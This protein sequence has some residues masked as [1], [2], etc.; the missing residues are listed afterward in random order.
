VQPPSKL[1]LDSNHLR[2]GP[3]FGVLLLAHKDEQVNH[4]DI[5]GKRASEIKKDAAFCPG[6]ERLA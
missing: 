2:R 6:G 3:V 4:T 1:Q 5:I